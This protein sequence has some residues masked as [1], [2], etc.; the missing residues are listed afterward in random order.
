MC[1][2]AFGWRVPGL[3]FGPHFINLLENAFKHIFVIFAEPEMSEL[4]IFDMFSGTK[5]EMEFHVYYVALCNFNQEICC[6]LPFSP[7]HLS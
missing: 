3:D 7:F 2:T 1:L 6:F 4:K 5:V